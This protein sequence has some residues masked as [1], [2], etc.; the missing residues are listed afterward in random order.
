MK[1]NNLTRNLIHFLIIFS[2]AFISCVDKTENN[3]L[4]AKG[5]DRHIELHW[6]IVSDEVDYYRILAGTNGKDFSL[7]GTVSDTIYLDFVNDLGTDLQLYYKV[8]A[9]TAEKVET[10]GEIQVSTKSMS[11]EELL[12]MVQFYTFRYFWEGAEPNS[13]MAPERIHLDGDYPDNDADVV[14]TGGTGFGIFGILAGIERQWI[15][16]EQG[17]ERFERMVGFLEYADRFNGFWPH[18]LYGKTG[19]VKPFSPNDNGADLVESAFLMQGL[20]AVREYY[21]QGNEREQNLAL[22]INQ[23]WEEMDWNWHTKDGD[24]VLYWH[25]S[26]DKEWLIQHPIRGYDECFIAYVL[27]ASSPTHS[28]SAEVFHKGWARGG[29]IRNEVTTDGYNLAMKHN[30]AEKYGGPLFWAHYSFLGLN[31][32]GLSDQYGD[33]WENNLN[34]TLLNRAWCVRNEGGFKGYGEDLWGLTASYSTVGYSAHHPGN[35]LGVISPTAALS[36]IPYTP[37]ESMDVIKNLYYN[38]GEKVFGKYGFYDALSPEED[39]YPQRYLAIDQGPI[40]AMIENHRTGLGW[41]LFMAAP[42]IH[43]GLE[44]LGISS[45]VFEVNDVEVINAR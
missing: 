1:N 8:E 11:E 38:Y 2:G 36:S 18:W 5:Y 28:I 17:L 33:Y 31:P 6:N 42:E 34:H 21:R 24:G 35:D 12:D 13:G 22:K 45:L 30:G 14:T 29:A 39:W 3:A 4:T 9:V 27:A 32:K 25:W 23:L 41:K 26:P 19:K 7:R 40:A 43:Q 15:K 44:K 37:E 20:L 10:L 16:R